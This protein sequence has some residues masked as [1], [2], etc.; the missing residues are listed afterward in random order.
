MYNLHCVLN[1]KAFQQIVH[2]ES[3][4]AIDVNVPA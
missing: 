3:D 1:R 2:F 4:F